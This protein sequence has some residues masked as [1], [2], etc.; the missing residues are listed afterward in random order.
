[1][2]GEKFQTLWMQ[3]PDAGQVN[4]QIKPNY[5]L[6]IAGIEAK[7]KEGNI[8]TMASGQIGDE[9]KFYFHC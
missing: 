7:M 6:N 2:D 9:L 8:S 4:K 5:Q 3:L 1:M